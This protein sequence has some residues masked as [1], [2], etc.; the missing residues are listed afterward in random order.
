MEVFLDAKPSEGHVVSEYN[1]AL[2]WYSSK[3]D[4]YCQSLAKDASLLNPSDISIVV[5][6]TRNLYTVEIPDDNG[7]NY[8]D[9]NSETGKD[10]VSRLVSI[11]R[12]DKELKEAY[13]GRLSEL[14]KE[15][16]KFAPR[17][18]FSDTYVQLAELLG[19]DKKASQL[20]SSLG[21]AGIK[22]PA[23]FRSGG[24]K[25]GA[26]NYVIFNEN[27]AKITDHVRFFKT[28][29]GEA[30]GFT[31]GG[32][33]YYDPRIANAET[34][35]HEYAHLWAS[36]LKANNAEEWKNVVD[37]MKGTNVWEEVKKAY[38]ELETDDEIADEVLATYSGRRGA[39]RLREE[40]RKAAAE[41]DGVM[42]KAEAV[43]ALQ[44]VKRA[45]DKFWKAVAD[46][47]HIHYTSAEEVADR[48]MKDL[49][50]GVDPRSM[51]DGGKSLRPETRVNV[52]EAEAGHGFKN[53]AE[54]KTWAKEHIARTYSGE[55]TGGKGDIRISNAAVDKYLSQSAVDKSESKDVH[56][57]VLKVLPDVIRE[58]V[59]AEQH[60]DFK[61]GKD[62]VRSAE[63]G[64]NPNVT[65]HRLYGAVRMD[66]KVYRVKVTLK[67]DKTSKE[68]KVPHSYEATKIELF[69][70][71]LGN[72]DN[73]LSPN[74]NNSITAANLLNGVDKSY[75]GGKF[76]E[77]Y[78][79]IREQ[80]IGEKGAA[81]ADHADEV[82]TRLD[83]LSVAREMEADKKDAKAIKMA[84]G[85]E[86]GADGKWRYEIPDMKEFDRNGNL[87]YRKN[88]PDYAR[89][90]ELL[91]KEDANLF[92]DGEALTVE[93]RAE[94]ETLSKKYE[95]DKFGGEKLDNNHTLEA[96]VDAPELFKAYPELKNVGLR[97]ENTGGNEIASYRYISSVFDVDKDDV[98][99]IVVNTGKVSKNTRTREVK[100]A[101]LHEMQHAI[102]EIEGFA[103][104]GSP[105][106]M[107]KRFEAAKEEW[108]ARAWADAL[109]YKAD[110]MGEHYNQ[111]AV[112][113]ALIDEYK[114]M[115]MDND[116]WMPDR[117]T[118]MKGFNYFARGYADRSMDSDIKN[119]RLNESTR[120]DFSPYVEYTR[121]AGEIGR[122]HV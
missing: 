69:A 120:A 43:S 95:S 86:R 27:D 44:R 51:M 60:A 58:S 81:A 55:E 64:V 89:Y 65:I 33:I 103:G 62:G 38:P 53:Y 97:F 63:N 5:D 87:L 71:T 36:A 22:Y 106:S 117:E 92:E 13:E 42:G 80:F 21:Y 2:D 102:Q 82:N 50:D 26:K 39:E 48:V 66:G 8:L 99:E 111:A 104:G 20:L 115:G 68:P 70:G 109:R 94:F 15:L 23:E 46:F 37:L 19:S 17:T 119:F 75:D 56:L 77:D 118:R 78:N 47:L 45:I 9:W 112:E 4:E 49:L 113:K 10:L 83:N 12:A 32:K 100:S 74:T 101:V 34:P 6:K 1:D 90:I 29:N 105:K 28:K 16:G 59:D 24:R 54:A 41:G 98:G 52:V 122:A 72:S 93:E 40:M 91:D 85:W 11:L 67:E 107:Q 116:E 57:A 73:S 7:K 79:K 96:Y 88:H 14:N 114:E 3:R 61:K 30:Y 18:L 35:V 31:V 121:L 108:R 110:E 84:T 76:F 25:D